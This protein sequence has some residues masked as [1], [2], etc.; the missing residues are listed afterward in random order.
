MDPEPNGGIYDR[1]H[2]TRL[3][4]WTRWRKTVTTTA[5]I[6]FSLACWSV[7]GCVSSS[8]C[9]CVCVFVL[10]VC[11]CFPRVLCLWVGSLVHVVRGV[12]VVAPFGPSFSRSLSVSLSLSLCLV[13]KR[14]VLHQGTDWNKSNKTCS[15]PRDSLG[16]RTN[17]YEGHKHRGTE[18]HTHTHTHTLGEGKRERVAVHRP[19]K[20]SR[21]KD[22][23]HAAIAN[24]VAAV[25]VLTRNICR[26]CPKE[27]TGYT[28]T[29]THTHKQ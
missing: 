1:N 4:G 8:L 26:H 27:T 17:H 22:V 5:C 16:G 9:C 29:H 13:L 14:I 12:F 15:K 19:H 2:W 21:R 23:Q 28:H 3:F 24:R 11:L 25:V 6:V 18:S 20:K 10:C 7:V